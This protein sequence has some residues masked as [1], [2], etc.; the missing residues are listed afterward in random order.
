MKVVQVLYSGLGGHASVAFTLASAGEALGWRTS[1]LFVGV[2]QLAPSHRVECQR[3][4][5]RHECVKTR[6]GRP[7]LSWPRLYL[8]LRRL[9]PDAIVLHS[10]K[11]I[12]PCALYGRLY[13][14]PLLAVE[15]QANALKKRSEWLVSRWLMRLADRV[16]VLTPTY[17]EQLHAKL[18]TDWRESKVEVIPNGIDLE[19]Y[20][21]APGRR[22]SSGPTTIGMAARITGIKRHDLLIDAV[23]LLC[24]RDGRDAWRLTLAGDGEGLAPL[25]DR[26]AAHDLQDIVT[27]PG[28]LDPPAMNSWFRGLDMYAH[29]SEGETL[30]MAILQAMAM[31]LPIVGSAVPGIE[32]LLGEGGGVGLAVPQSAQAFADAFTRLRD[33]PVLRIALSNH[34]RARAREA[35]SQEAMVAGYHAR[36]Q[37]LCA[38]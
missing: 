7:W 22:S 13:G 14:I 35:Y 30:S 1:M 31:G 2:E 15:H 32:E 17:R 34:A 16:V 33:D 38:G 28:F 18:G 5:Y 27:L 23:A 12:F 25:R 26:I 36:L 4:G 3:A 20:D 37:A 24:A 21:S 6:S 8:S 9:K 10:V 29:A 11:M 19:L